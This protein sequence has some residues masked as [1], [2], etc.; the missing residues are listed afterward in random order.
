MIGSVVASK[1]KHSRNPL[2]LMPSISSLKLYPRNG[3]VRLPV[4]ILRLASLS[5]LFGPNWARD[6]HSAYPMNQPNYDELIRNRRRKPDFSDHLAKLLHFGRVGLVVASYVEG[7]LRSAA[8]QRAAPVY[9]QK[10][11]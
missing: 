6:A 4:G 8:F 10:V 2:R 7:F 5:M 9:L 3:S 11:A 1:P